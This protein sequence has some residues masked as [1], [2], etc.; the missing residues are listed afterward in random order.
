MWLVVAFFVLSI[1]GSCMGKN[2]TPEG[3]KPTSS[4]TPRSTGT[5]P[6]GTHACPPTA[7]TAANAP[8]QRS[9]RQLSETSCGYAENLRAAYL[10]ALASGKRPTKLTAYSVQLGKNVTST[11]AGRAP[12]VCTTAAKAK[13]YFF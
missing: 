13:I 11:C 2:R 3:L 1:F 9:S 10:K 6:R 5:L 12:V 4:S 8:Y 7:K